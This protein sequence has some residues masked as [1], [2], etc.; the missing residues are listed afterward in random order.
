MSFLRQLG[1]LIWKNLLF[2]IFR[3]PVGFVIKFYAIPLVIFSVLVRIPVW[4]TRIDDFK[5][6]Q[7]ATLGSLSHAIS[8]NLAVI[9]PPKAGA[10]IQQLIDKFTQPIGA[11]RL[12]YLDN[13]NELLEKCSTDKYGCHNSVTFLD[14][15][16]T[17][18]INAT[19]SYIIRSD[20]DLRGTHTGGL[21][22][23][24]MP[25]Q[26]A[27]NNAITNSSVVPEAFAFGPS[28]DGGKQDVYNSALDI[29]TK[30]Y[31]FIVFGAHLFTVYQITSW[32]TNDRDSGASALIDSM[33]GRWAS[34][35]RTL[36]WVIVLDIVCMPLFIIFGVLYWKLLF[37]LSSSSLLIGWQILLGLSLNSA[38]VFA[39]SFF[40]KARIS[41]ILVC[42][43]FMGLA[44]ASQF[45]TTRTHPVPAPNIVK[46][47]S[48]LFPSSGYT[49]FMFDMAEWQK[50]GLPADIS[51]FPPVEK[52]FNNTP[53]LYVITQS[54]VLVALG[55]QILAY[56]GLALL[57]E[58]LM[59]GLNFKGRHFSKQPGTP[60]TAAV[61][62]RNLRKEFKPGF[63]ARIFCCGRRKSNLAVD[64]VSLE[65]HRGQIMCLVGQNGSGKT[66]TL[67]MIGGFLGLNAGQVSFDA[68]PSQI[69]ICPQKNVFW[70]E[71]TVREH[72][73]LWS[74]IKSG[75][76][77]REQIDQLIAD[78]DL[79]HKSNCLAKNL[80][81]GQKRKLQLACM[82]IGE[83]SICLIDE[84]TSG[85][86][87]LSRQAIWDLLLRNRTNRSM[88][89]TT[90]FLDEVDV[91]ADY[92]VVLQYGKVKSQGSSAELNSTHGGG[93]KVIVERTP[94]SLGVV[95]PQE[96]TLWQDRLVYK[97]ADSV[98][99]TRLTNTFAAAGVHDVVIAGPQFEEVFLNLAGEGD[100]TEIKAIS[101]TDR[102]NQM[103][104]GRETSFGKQVGILFGKRFM[105]LPRVWFPYFFLVAIVV[106]AA[107]GIMT[108]L[109][110][111][112]PETCDHYVPR[113]YPAGTYSF[114]VN[115]QCKQFDSCN[116]LNFGPP[117]ANS[118]LF[119]IV[120]KGYQSLNSIA[121]DQFTSF[122]TILDN[123]KA[124]IDYLKSQD[125]YFLQAGIYFGN[126]KDEVPAIG[127]PYGGGI[128][129]PLGASLLNIW[130]Q[131]NSQ[132]EIDVQYG[133]LPT[134]PKVRGYMYP[135]SRNL[136][137]NK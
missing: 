6:E 87:P 81:G 11:G 103:S 116:S 135:A 15:P 14:S 119:D 39:A 91:L 94:R 80:S 55:V 71:L 19:W 42:I 9:R 48:F 113:L 104:P 118:S 121:P 108:S 24:Y 20:S 54:A 65:A 1:A 92:I 16:E 33:G 29:I 127:Y 51:R 28:F 44:V 114:F 105:V 17:K 59:H 23:V 4:V 89:F 22:N 112:L 13:E 107:F 72:I 129:D 130:S 99:A 57:S 106:A 123:K 56:L 102:N 101:F 134:I 7:P 90:H 32:V 64:D 10:D 79:A 69:G 41:A 78:C 38:A 53:D 49:L 83:S 120:Q 27:I 76:E 66:T 30:I 62:T 85:L 82:F 111:F 40:S 126:G 60:N 25:L 26:L 47:L 97:V 137:A 98:T 67:Q 3:H 86:D 45:Q 133:S 61:S 18:A 125:R 68:T 95:V 93:Y 52:S 31:A 35:A 115:D 110:K 34:L 77:T 37:P 50:T 75:K 2:T 43:V 63:F 88:I 21:E 8:G 136:R 73:V 46:A 132:I 109:S 36:S 100:D 70:E 5:T 12:L 128:S 84:C 122:V 58:W 124:W 74:G 131:A 117:S 96:A